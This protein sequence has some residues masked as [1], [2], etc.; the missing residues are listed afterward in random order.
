MILLRDYQNKILDDTRSL[1]LKNENSVL[2]CSPTGSGKTALTAHMLLSAQER[3]MPSWFVV[4][5]RE[6]I[7]QSRSTFH[8]VGLKHGIIAA[9]YDDTS[10][11]IKICS[12]QTLARRL[13]FVKKPTMIVWDE[14]HHVAAKSWSTIHS[15]FKDAIHIGLS[16]TPL[17]LDGAG[18]G[19]W[20]DKLVLGPTVNDLIKDK[21][22]S[23][24]K[25]YAPSRPDLSGISTIMG[26]FEK[27][28]L[29]IAMDKPS[30][31]GNVVVEYNKLA[32]GKRAILRAVSIKHSQNIADKFNASGIPAKHVDGNTHHDERDRALKQFE[33][34]EILVL[35]N[36]DLFSEGVD[37]PAIECAIDLRPTQSLTLWLQFCGRALRYTTDNKTAIIID[38]AGNVYRHGFPDDIRDWTLEEGKKLTKKQKKEVPIR[39]C[40]KCFAVLPASSTYCKYCEHTLTVQGRVVDEKEGD[41]LEVKNTELIAKK[42]E[43]K[44]ATSLE[45]LISLGK[46][47]GYKNPHYWAKMVMNGRQ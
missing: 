12:I 37:I 8:K 40:D 35:C 44:M 1:L 30:I 4:H 29:A 41:L 20:F 22:L 9:D 25:L 5:R 27:T 2:I 42:K 32:Q 36:V 47:R 3:G 7:N 24:F 15:A 23:P 18:L 19:G 38:H 11:I 45:Q 39:N 34:G 6:L 26:D 10:D 31:T 21:W 17:R 13:A 28:E 46:K 14:C 43:R 16:A 33:R